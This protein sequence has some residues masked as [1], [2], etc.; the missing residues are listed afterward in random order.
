M[1]ASAQAAFERVESVTSPPLADASACLQTQ[2]AVLAV[3]LPGEESEL[4]YRKGFCELAVAAVTRDPSAFTDAAAELDKAGANMLAWLARRAGHLPGPAAE[5]P[6]WNEPDSC[7]KSCEPLLPVAKVW[8]GWAALN[9]GNAIAAAVQFDAR[10]N[11]GWPPYIAG[12]MAF[13][14]GRYAESTA[15]YREALEIWTRDQQETNPTLALRLSPP[16]DVPQL[17][18]EL[19]GALI[20]A[21]DPRGAIAQLDR[22]AQ[23]SPKAR[24]FFLRARAKEMTGQS[25]AALAD[26]NLASRAAFADANDLASGEAHLYRGIMLYRRKDYLKAEEEFASALNFEIAPTMRPDAA[27]WRHLSAVASGFCGASRQYLEK[28]LPSVS[29]YFPK[30]EAEAMAAG[31]SA[32][33]AP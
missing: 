17:L 15:R 6:A 32:G 27:A 8:K 9:A 21:G 10:P 22:A 2:A 33:L 28:S 25:E 20:L 5:Q 23:A 18:T 30:A 14:G 29:P 13:R 12:L 19:G 7:P 3:A 31:C 1:L 16:E 24:A 4:H 26:Y 11:S